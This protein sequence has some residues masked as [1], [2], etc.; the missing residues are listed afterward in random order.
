MQCGKA[1]VKVLAAPFPVSFRREHVSRETS[2]S[3]AGILVDFHS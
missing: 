2:N 1:L 3:G